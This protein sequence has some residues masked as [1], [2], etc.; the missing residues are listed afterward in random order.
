MKHRNRNSHAFTLIELL[1]VIAIIAI[2]AAM[3]LPALNKAREKARSITC[4]NNLKQLGTYFQMYSMDYNDW[5][6]RGRELVGTTT[7]NL[8]PQ[9]LCN[10]NYLPANTYKKKKGT[11]F[12]CPA[13]RNPEYKPGS[14]GTVCNSYGINACIAQGL[15][16]VVTDAPAGISCRDRWRK[17]GSLQGTKKKASRT[18]L[19]CD[20]WSRESSGT[21]TAKKYMVLRSG[22]ASSTDLSSWL[23]PFYSPGFIGLVHDNRA[24]NT[25]FCDGHARTVRGPMYNT[26]TVS[27]YVQWLN[28][29]A[30]DGIS[31]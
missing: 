6:V 31:Y 16:G 5:I 13:D 21:L 10:L 11:P 19:L 3:L 18:P 20:S 27:S 24:T 1:V 15:Y 4:V 25:M 12:I 26:E 22:G 29:D 14:A 30:P 2:L 17:L 23:N 28:P 9:T 7:G 8:W